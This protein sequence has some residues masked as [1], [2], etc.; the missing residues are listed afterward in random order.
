MSDDTVVGQDY[1]C[2][3]RSV[4]NRPVDICQRG[5]EVMRS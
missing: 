2:M 4:F 1:N 5:S 3:V